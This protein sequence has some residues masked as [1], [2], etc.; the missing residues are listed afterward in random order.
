[1]EPVNKITDKSLISKMFVYSAMKISANIL[2]LYSVLK[3][4]TSSDSPSAK[5]NGVRLV[6]AKFVVN[7]ITSI[8]INISI[9]HDFIF[10]GIIDIS[11]DWIVTRAPNIISAIDTS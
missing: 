10:I 2:L 8:G 6:S 5:S 4:E 11:I 3:P 1:M 9:T 7:Q